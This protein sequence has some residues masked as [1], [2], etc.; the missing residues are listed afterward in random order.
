MTPRARNDEGNKWRKWIGPF[1][2][3]ASVFG[4]LIA[5]E[6][7]SPTAAFFVALSI[8]VVGFILLRII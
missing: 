5:A 8:I 2:V 3:S 4:V 6:T 1:I 7:I